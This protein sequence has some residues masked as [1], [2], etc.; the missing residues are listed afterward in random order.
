MNEKVEIHIV[1]PLCDKETKEKVA[2]YVGGFVS[3][4]HPSC[5]KIAENVISLYER[6]VLFHYKLRR[7]IHE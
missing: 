7:E 2:H 4:A 6:W 5:M 3:Y 1:C